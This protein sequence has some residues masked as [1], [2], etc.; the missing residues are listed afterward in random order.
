MSPRSA[1]FTLSTGDRWYVAMIPVP[2]TSEPNSRSDAKGVRRR[3]EILAAAARIFF[4]KGYDATSTKDIADAAGLLKGS[5]YYYVETKED[6]L[7]EI[8]KENYDGAIATLDRVRRFEGQALERL[9]RL[10]GEHFRYFVDNI[11]TT[12]VFFREFR[13][14]SAE[15]QAVIAAE[16][17]EY[18]D[19]VR[20]LLLQ[21]QREGSVAPEL[22]V[23]LISIGIVGMI[24]S[25]WLWYQPGGSRSTDEIA[26]EFVKVIVSGI[27]SDTA[28]V[29]AGSAAQLR[30]SIAEYSAALPTEPGTDL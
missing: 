17:D 23:R 27:A 4:E 26:A 16:G 18:L 1:A 3:R 14:L 12:T 28:L 7:F 22:D 30:S 6:F 10:V 15:R 25:A 9:A 13:V 20:E 24:N 5:L 8:I 11:E 2:A 21:G 19:F 29:E